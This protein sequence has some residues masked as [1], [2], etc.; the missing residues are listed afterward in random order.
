MIKNTL[1][2]EFPLTQTNVTFCY[3]KKAYEK[4]MSKN[5]DPDG[6]I[7]LDAITSTITNN[8]TGEFVIVIGCLKIK[9][10]YTLKALLVH[11]MSHAVTEW[12]NY[13]GFNCDEVRSYAL[14][15]L[16]TEI[17]TFL[18]NLIEEKK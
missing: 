9:N 14:Q 8:I 1:T 18:D 13:F 3:G 5:D 16:Y 15:Y 10:I 6:E 2:I 7:R 11:E 17:I 4:Y 12:M